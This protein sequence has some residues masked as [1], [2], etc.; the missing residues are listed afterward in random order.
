MVVE[1]LKWDQAVFDAAGADE[2]PVGE[3]QDDWTHGDLDKGFEDAELVMDES[4]YTASLT[5]HPLEP[6]SCMAYWQNGKCYL[7][8]SSQSIAIGHLATAGQIG[9]DMKDLVFISEFCGG[10]FGSKITGSSNMAIPAVLAKKTGRPVMHRVSRYEENYFGR[11]RPA[12]HVKAKVGFKKNGPDQR[13]GPVRDPGQRSVRAPGRPGH[14]RGVA[15]LTYQPESM[16]FR[17]VSVLTNTPP[18]APQ[19]AP[20]GAQINTILEPMLDRAARQLGMDRVEIRK[21]NAPEKGAKFGAELGSNVTTA[22]C[23]EALDKLAEMVDWEEAKQRSGQRNGNKITGVGLALASF[24]AGNFNYDGLM[25]ITPEGRLRLHSGVGNLG[26]HSMADTS[27]VAA[28]VLG[29]DW[30]QCDVLWGDT[31]RGVPWTCVQAGSMTTHSISR[32]VHAGAMDAK[33]KLQEIAAK[34]LGGSPEQYETE[35][36]RVFRKGNP[37]RGMSLAQA[38]KRASSWAAS[39]TGTR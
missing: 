25:V 23:D 28:D 15:S 8:C 17:G 20:G 31:S 24:T 34:D 30:D 33:Q 36:G 1:D 9:V 13:H 2:V 21:L 18:R 6:R 26:T 38:A 35:G 12:F 11:A 29:M 39:T 16:R 37:G 5:H 22:Y 14:G 3:T 27:R 7:H 19:R 32:A 4:F 10:G